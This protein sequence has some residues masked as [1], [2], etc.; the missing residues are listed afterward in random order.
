MKITYIANIRI[1]TEKAH[2]YAIMKMC[3]Q[4]AKL[5]ASLDLVVPDRRNQLKEDPFY[6]TELMGY[7]K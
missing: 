5:G 6:F 1:P 2:G 3:E 4:F 7:S